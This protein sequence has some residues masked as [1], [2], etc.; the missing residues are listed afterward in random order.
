MDTDMSASG[1][2]DPQ[3][4][5][6]E[7]FPS[8][9]N[10][11][12][13]LFEST[14]E[15]EF[16]F[17]E[18]GLELAADDAACDLEEELRDL[19]RENSEGSAFQSGSITPDGLIDEDFEKE[20]GTPSDGEE[21]DEGEFQ[22]VAQHNI[23]EVAGDD[24][25]GRKVIIFSS[26]KLPSSEKL[27]HQ[28]LFLYLKHTLDQYVENDYV[29]VYFHYGLTS[30]N[31]P[32][33]SWLLQVYRELDRK[34]KKNLKALYLVHPT[35][36]IKILW[37]VFKPFISAKFGR[38]VMYVNYLHELKEHLHF[39]QLV[40]PEPVLQ[41][42]AK[43]VKSNKPPYPYSGDR[44]DDSSGAQKTQQFGVTLSHIRQNYKCVI[45]PVVE[46]SVEYLRVNALDVEGIFRRSANA[47]TLKEVQKKFNQGLTV[48]FCTEGD[49][50]IAAVILKTFL[51]ELQEPLLTFDL[52][53]PIVRLHNQDEGRQMVDV[54]RMLREELPEDNYIILKYILQFLTEIVAHCEENKMTSMNLSIVFGPNLLWPKGQASLSA[55]GYL[56]NF[57]RYLIDHYRDLFES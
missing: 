25:Y 11:D 13:Q 57:T 20:L 41:Y 30:K 2:G 14:E 28:R 29:I 46:I 31:K 43:Q 5:I 15:P 51:R 53:Q 34:Y 3:P 42:D 33:L 9:G 26:C 19:A 22:D 4:Y 16:E 32:K 48:D 52:Y 8:D 38:K 6:N 23:L 17:D 36:F 37:N 55:M 45:P 35:R 39:D 21:E 12:G 27:D 24:V 47:R 1:G 40:V 10:E 50:H 7:D 18:S 44:V 49:V 56:N 54:Q